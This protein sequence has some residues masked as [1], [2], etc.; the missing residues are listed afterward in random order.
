MCDRVRVTKDIVRHAYPVCAWPG[1]RPAPAERKRCLLLESEKHA[2]TAELDTSGL[3]WSE[4]IPIG[5]GVAD[6]AATI[7]DQEDRRQLREGEFLT[8]IANV[9][10]EAVE[11][12]RR[13]AEL[14]GRKVSA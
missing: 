5:I 1:F 10:A 8:S 3:W 7:Y 11:L 6:G 14:E 2:L 13:L 4:E 12:R 9:R